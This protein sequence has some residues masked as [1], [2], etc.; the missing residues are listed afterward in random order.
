MENEYL[1]EPNLDPTA[2]P[3]RVFLEPL[4]DSNVRSSGTTR[5]T[6]SV[7]S[8]S[9]SADRAAT[10]S[11]P[12]TTA[13]TTTPAR[14]FR[15]GPYGVSACTACVETTVLDRVLCSFDLRIC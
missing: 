14:R 5:S 12:A 1:M 8:Q 13:P 7:A 10:Y 2:V 3:P 9:C 11:N 6:A 4:G 15:I